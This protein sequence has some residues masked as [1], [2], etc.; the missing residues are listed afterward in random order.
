MIYEIQSFPFPAGLLPGGQV[1]NRKSLDVTPHAASVREYVH[2]DALKRIHWLTSARR[3]R[4]MVKEF[5]QDPQTEIWL[6]LDLHWMM[7]SEKPH[8]Y[9]ELPIDAMIFAKRPDFKL[10]PST[11]EYAVSIAASLA[12][13]FIAQRRA[14]GYASAGH[15]LSIHPAE[16]S[17]R[18]E[19]KILETLAF[20]EANGTLSIAE[21]VA[22][23]AS[24]LPKA[25]TAILVT[26]TVHPNLLQAVDDLLLRHLRPV[27]ILLDAASFGGPRGTENLHTALHERRVPVSVI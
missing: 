12:H 25:S 15:A 22:V 8:Q 4:L 13:Y 23:H 16:R 26:T 24:Q 9:E 18:Q 14:V 6:F 21:L 5:E 17:E 1:I 27:V 7:H 3:N 10:P 2:G 19:A 11:L 20:V